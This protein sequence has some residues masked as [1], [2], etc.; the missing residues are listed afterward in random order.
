MKRTLPVLFVLTLAAFQTLSA[1]LPGRVNIRGILHDTS[2][3]AVSGA[4]VMLLNPTDSTLVNF[5]AADKSGGFRFNSVKN[6]PF[7]LKVS[8]VAFMPHQMSISRSAVVD[9][10][11]GVITLTP[12]SQILMQVVVRD[13][14]APIRIH[15]DTVEYDVTTFKVPPGSTVEDLLRRL[16]GI[17]VDASGNVSAQGKDVKRI[18]VDGKSF[19]GEDPKTVTQNLGSEAIS[20]VQVYDEKSDQAKLTGV[21]DPSLDKAMNLELKEE[22]KKGAFGKATLAGGTEE[23]WAAKG[24][25]NKFDEKQQFSFIGY[26]NNINQSGVNWED[27]REFQGQTGFSE[28]DNGDFG[29]SGGGRIYYSSYS[30]MPINRDAD[31]GFSNNS[32]AGVNYN[33]DNKKT[34]FNTSY[35][36]SQSTLWLDQQSY[37]QTFLKDSSYYTRDTLAME[38]FR[39]NHSFSARMEHEFDSTRTL[40]AKANL[41]ITP[42]STENR[43]DQFFSLSSGEQINNLFTSDT[44]ESASTRANASIV[45]GRRFKKAG[46]AYGISAGYNYQQSS[47]DQWLTSLNR[48]FLAGTPEEQIRQLNASTGTTSAVKSS[49]I[50][51]DAISKMFFVEGFYNITYSSQG[52]NNQVD[53]LLPLDPAR[54]DSL[55]LFYNNNVLYNRLGGSLR[56]ANKGTNA[57]VGIAVQNLDMTMAYAPDQGEQWSVDP[58]KRSFLNYTPNVSVSQEFPNNV[59]LEANY[60]Y[61]ISEPQFS[62]LMPK[63]TISNPLYR[64]LGNPDLK[65]E[66]SH[67][68]G[69][70]LHY[71]APASFAS[72]GLN[73]S[74]ELY[75]RKI[76]YNMTTDFI[77]SLGYRTIT[78]PENISGGD[79]LSGYF[80]SSIPV[81]KTILSLNISGSFRIGN[82]Q[83]YINEDLNLT[84]TQ[85]YSAS[86]GINLTPGTKLQLYFSGRLGYTDI[87]YSIQAEQNQQI[88]NHSA[89]ATIRYQFIAKT[90]FESNFNYTLYRNDRFG[91]DQTIP[92]WNASIRRVFGEKNRLEAR[93]AAF[94]LLNKRLGI[95][96]TG[97][98][99]YVLQTTASTLARYYMLSV[100]YNIRGY[101]VKLQKGG[102]FSFF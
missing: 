67:S 45:Y 80:W 64:N 58:L 34:Q 94:D 65:P 2:G 96:Q 40:V 15:G 38:D 84:H 56:F 31:R 37:R 61:Q 70:S 76:V 54:I 93:F 73:G 72:F 53:D 69:T 99:N 43:K 17:E 6:E 22:F 90:F 41:S 51:T 81:I 28:Y 23:R 52:K 12:F 29:F 47:N 39:G 100:S 71:W 44:T 97:A 75:D 49:A 10:N 25:Y 21:P 98:A 48:F 92:L 50:Y 62:D 1:Q 26:A 60:S 74:Y 33:F 88:Q 46:K 7:L 91:F 8:H 86:V 18:Y 30:S 66:K 3:V 63:P 79:E 32:G 35:F 36:Y 14:R 101:D 13:A 59:Y 20:K 24:N 95:T 16:P 42:S 55:S 102:R 89:S 83:A 87:G 9:A 5:T 82:S 85:G 78:R 57:S 11:L 77:D 4:T 27:Y 68:I 19:F